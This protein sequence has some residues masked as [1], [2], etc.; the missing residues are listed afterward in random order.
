MET[1][2]KP[3]QS[4]ASSFPLWLGVC[5]AFALLI[6]AWSTLIVIARDNPI[7]EVPLAPP[8]PEEPAE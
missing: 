3:D 7:E 2:V 4:P 5:L 1:N 6:A 8:S